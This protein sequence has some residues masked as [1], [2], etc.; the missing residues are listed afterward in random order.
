MARTMAANCILWSL[1]LGYIGTRVINWSN[2]IKDIR[3]RELW[4]IWNVIN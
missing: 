2:I 1:I 4:R 3:K